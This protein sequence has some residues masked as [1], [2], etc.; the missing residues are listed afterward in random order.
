MRGNNGAGSSCVLW[1]INRSVGT[2]RK[3]KVQ[4][5]TTISLK[6]D[7]KKDTEDYGTLTKKN[8][9]VGDQKMNHPELIW[10]HLKVKEWKFRWRGEVDRNYS[11]KKSRTRRQVRERG[12]EERQG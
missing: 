11:L 3:K 8:Q 5:E 6:E 1:P 2:A 7:K 12:W 10:Y 9:S 4:N